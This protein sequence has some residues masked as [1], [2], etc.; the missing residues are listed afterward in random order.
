MRGWAEF[1]S[2]FRRNRGALVGLA[3][4]F[5][6]VTMAVV[7]PFLYPDDPF[8]MVAQPFLWPFQDRAFPLGSDTLGRDLIAQIFH[9]AHV[10]LLIGATATIASVAI[11]IVIGALAGF[12]GGR[13]DDVLMRL[14]E[15]FQTIPPFILTVI[16]VAVFRP[17]ISTIVLA[18]CV[19]SWPSVARLVRAE[20]LTLREREF[21]Q[22]GVAMGMSDLRLI[23]TQILPN[24]MTP[25]IVAA[26][27]MMATSILIEA[28]LS[29]LGLGDPNVVSWGGIIGAGRDSIRDAWYISAIPGVAIFA[30]VLGLNLVG[31]G[32]NDALNPRLRRR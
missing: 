8:D 14:T 19:V 28:G 15:V 29:F 31:E 11:G 6:I 9:G 5:A 24:A 26:S 25:V 16:M 4:V 23:V 21:I 7:A 30:A 2:R 17:S 12:Y 22:A 18:I 32:L 3:I 13:I 1:W 10:S 20:V 27:L